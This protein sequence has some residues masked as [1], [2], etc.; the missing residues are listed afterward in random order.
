MNPS[1][2]K[3]MRY[4]ITRNGLP[5]TSS[6]GCKYIFYDVDMTDNHIREGGDGVTVYLSARSVGGTW[7]S[8][9]HVLWP[10]GARSWFVCI[11]HTCAGRN[12]TARRRIKRN[13]VIRSNGIRPSV[14]IRCVCVF[15]RCGCWFPNHL[16]R[17]I[18]YMKKIMRKLCTYRENWPA[19]WRILLMCDVWPHSSTGTHSFRSC[20]FTCHI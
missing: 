14:T 16:I 4:Y 11:F 1:E 2:S 5:I 15:V 3:N 19:R 8:S 6:R 17:H 9:V 12:N 7:R 13:G 18:I 20:Y 10:T